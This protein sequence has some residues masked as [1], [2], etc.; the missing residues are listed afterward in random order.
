METRAELRVDAKQHPTPPS[1]SGKDGGTLYLIQTGTIQTGTRGTERAVLTLQM[2]KTRQKSCRVIKGRPDCAQAGAGSRPDRKDPS[3]LRGRSDS[4][5]ARLPSG[6]QW[7]TPPAHLDVFGKLTPPS[8][9]R[10]PTAEGIPG[11][12]GRARR[13]EAAGERAPSV[14]IYFSQLEDAEASCR[15]H[16][17]QPGPLGARLLLN[18]LV[19]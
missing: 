1:E 15:H 3:G 5:R 2:E 10:I 19:A 11:G 18:R 12:A 13:C 6:P 9:P 8:R 14:A 17:P 7:Q 16:Q 4:A